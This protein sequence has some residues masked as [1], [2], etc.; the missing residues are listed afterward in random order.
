M[1]PGHSEE[2]KMRREL[3]NVMLKVIDEPRAIDLPIEAAPYHQMLEALGAASAPEGVIRLARES[4]DSANA[5]V[6]DGLVQ[7][8][9]IAAEFRV[10]SLIADGIVVGSH[11]IIPCDSS[12]FEGSD[13]IIAAIATLGPRLEQT[14]T[15]AFAGNNP[16]LAI[17]LDAAGTILIRNASIQFQ[18]DCA[19]RAG[20]IG[21]E[22]GPRVSPGCRAVP[23]EAQKALFSLLDA[24]SVGVTLTDSLLMTPVK[25]VSLMFPLG[26]SLPERL[27]VFNICHACRHSNRCAQIALTPGRTGTP[28]WTASRPHTP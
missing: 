10:D 16:L 11:T 24:Q 23:L 26:A 19:A 12:V 5:M 27:R 22:L 8:R 25:S 3:R 7:P 1:T 14:V 4:I 20:A 13:R 15:S 6:A 2:T 21:L 17:T 28:R 9:L 18:R